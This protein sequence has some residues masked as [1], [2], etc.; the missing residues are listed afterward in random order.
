V[1][2]AV[3]VMVAVAG[4]KAL[5]MACTI[6]A[7]VVV[8]RRLGPAALGQ[9]TLLIAAGTLLHTFLVNWTHPATVRYG[10]EEFVLTG[11]MRRTLTARLLLVMTSVAAAA[12][13]LFW[14]PGGWLERWFATAPTH[15]A[16]VA[17]LAIN[18][19]VVAEAQG[20][21][22][23]TDRIIWQ[24]VLAPLAGV[25]SIVAL[26][27][28]ALFGQLTIGRAAVAFALPPIVI[29]GSAWILALARAQAR[30]GPLVRADI[31]RGARYGL[32]M[33]PAFVIGYFSDWGG[34][35]L[36]KQMSSLEEV[37]WF[38]L[39]YQFMMAIVAANGMLIIVLLPRLIAHEVRSVGYMRIYIESEIPTLYALWMVGTIWSIALVPVIARL[40][41]GPGFDGRPVGVLLV[42]LI[43]VPC[44]ALNS[45]YVVLFN[46]QERTG[47]L[48]LYIALMTVIGV[49]VSIM[50]IP[51]YGAMG[52]A[53]GTV[54]SYLVYQAVYVWDQ[55][56]RFGVP[57]GPIWIVSIV[58]VA[59][60]TLQV[61]V[62][63]GFVE[64]VVWAG[65]STIAL[66]VVIRLIGC[67]DANLVIRLCGSRVG[68]A[69]LIN[70]ALVVRTESA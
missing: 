68:P 32:P 11:T 48:L 44:S 29:W 5:A 16:S 46:V 51:S 62:G 42:L 14:Q 55:H 69:R 54:V 34:H 64:R 60:V 33:L 21:L 18:V 13:L 9:W 40:M 59:L 22:Q 4:G 53:F 8:G 67:I 15:E 52:A 36:L 31:W 49:G 38:S 39:A 1:N 41:V 25:V 7:A 47:H 58:G 66:M 24:A 12:A 45:L 28:T 17:L 6:G 35:L 57:A 70:R 43:A 56:Q 65:S 3:L 10:R 30:P 27:M 20:T 2:S 23:A 50:L 61:F 37:G 26:V 19:W 63:A